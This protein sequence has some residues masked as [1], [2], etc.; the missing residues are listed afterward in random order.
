MKV[1]LINQEDAQN[2][3]KLWTQV[4]SVCYDSA[5]KNP[6]GIG[7]HCLKSG[8]T[9]GSR[10]TYFVFKITG[11]PR[12]VVDQ[13]I[14]HEDG[15]YKNVGSFRYIDKSTFMYEIPSEII[16]NDELLKDYIDYMDRGVDIYTR[17]QS[18]VLD[19]TK[20]KERANEQARYVLTMATHTA[21]C[22]GFDIEA[23]IHYLGKRLCV[24]T[25]DVHRKMAIMIRDEVLKVFPELKDKLVPQ[26]KQ[27]LWCPESKSCHAYPTK[28]E[29]ANMINE[30]RC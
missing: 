11:V 1:E 16:D 13:A 23:L 15:V 7:K 25:E 28:Q 10:G 18:Y 27:L 21:F 9:S 2:L 24:R 6:E 8:H 29:L 17:I 30:Q 14:R 20:E 3:F 5:I 12:F 4:A 19:K 22:I 26:C